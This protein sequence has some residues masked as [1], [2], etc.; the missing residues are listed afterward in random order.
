LIG[1]V[2]LPLRTIGSTAN[3]VSDSSGQNTGAIRSR[4]LLLNQAGKIITRPIPGV[5][6]PG[7]FE[8]AYYSP[9]LKN[10]IA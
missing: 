2:T 8:D 1:Q 9:I 10:L 3:S 6:F 4:L 7:F 5:K